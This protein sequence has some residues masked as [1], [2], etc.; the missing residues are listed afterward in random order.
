MDKIVSHPLTFGI[1]CVCA[2]V[3]VR[4]CVCVCVHKNVLL[5]KLVKRSKKLLDYLDVNSI[6]FFIPDIMNILFIL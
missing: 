5:F 3:C 1:L 6:L 2:Y 4:A